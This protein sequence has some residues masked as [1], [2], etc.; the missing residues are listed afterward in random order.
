MKLS[1]RVEKFGIAPAIGVILLL[2]PIFVG[3]SEFYLNAVIMMGIFLILAVGFQFLLQSGILNFG[4][5]VFMGVGSYASAFLVNS[6]GLPF[7]PALLIS[8][9]VAAVVAV[10][11]GYPTLRVAGA[12]FFMIS[13][14]LVVLFQ[15]V[16][17]SYGISYFGGP[18]GISGVPHPSITIPG[19]SPVVLSSGTSYYYLTLVIVIVTIW[20]FYRLERGRFGKTCLLIGSSEVLARSLGINIFR[21]RMIALTISC[22]FAGIAGSLYVHY[23]T[24]VT[25][26]D[27]GIAQSLTM[28]VYAF[29]GGIGSVFGPVVG[30]VVMGTIGIFI[31]ELGE[32]EM[33]V[34]GIILVIIIIR[35]PGGLWGVIQRV[36]GKATYERGLLG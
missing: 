34:Y 17:T 4:H 15:L 1:E 20:V 10:L 7:W 5:I 9:I 31:I 35:A 25:P 21:T 33:L 18:S 22:F 23:M 36:R 27:F 12:A 14:S 3:K 8:G 2:F 6:L 30:A 16:M 32:W 26:I 13:L 11:F 24:I 29:V 19:L 28:Q